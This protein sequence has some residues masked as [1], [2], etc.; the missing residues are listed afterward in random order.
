MILHPLRFYRAGIAVVLVLALGATQGSLAETPKKAPVTLIVTIRED[1][2][3]KIA[4]DPTEQKGK[5]RK[6]IS[7][8]LDPGKTFTYKLVAQWMPNNYET[9]TRTKV[10]EVKAGETVKVDMTVKDPKVLD[11]IFIRYVPTPPTFVDAMCKLAKI[12]KDDVVFDLGCGD[13]RLVIAAVE[14]FG[15]KKGVGID[16]DPER[17][18]ESKANASKTKVAEKLEFREG[19]VFKVPDL[20]NATVVMLYMSDGLGAQ[21]A[22]IL[23]KRLK[24]GSRIVT[25]RFLLGDWKPDKSEALREGDYEQKIYLWN[26][27]KKD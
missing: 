19:D 4:G 1:A 5:E 16:L 27:E 26:V 17:V 15:A 18:Q 21:L 20:E 24:P 3:L 7:P 23:K 9:Y 25:H 8:P 14:K 10:V 22:P 6:F 12:G 2:T 13:G 11:D